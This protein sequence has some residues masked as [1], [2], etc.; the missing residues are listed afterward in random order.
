[1]SIPEDLTASKAY[2]MSMNPGDFL[3]SAAML[4]VLDDIENP[5]S[6]SSASHIQPPV[7]NATRP[8]FAFAEEDCYLCESDDESCSVRHS[9]F[10]SLSSFVS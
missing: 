5:T 1:M 6:N 8:N 3:G 10:Y 2:D 7:S 4:L 9:R